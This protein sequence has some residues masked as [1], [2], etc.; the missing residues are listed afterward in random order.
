MTKNTAQTRVEYLEEELQKLESE[1]DNLLC[2]EQKTR[3]RLGEIEARKEQ[4]QG[5]P[6]KNHNRG[7]IFSTT[8]NLHAAK[9]TEA[10]ITKPQCVFISEDKKMY[11]SRVTPKRIY[12]IE[13]GGTAEISFEKTDGRNKSFRSMQIDVESSI[14]NWELSK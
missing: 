2:E 10:D 5:S 13:R 7:K 4:L 3:K 14:Q 6:F 1:Y 8:I 12:A 11:V 9:R